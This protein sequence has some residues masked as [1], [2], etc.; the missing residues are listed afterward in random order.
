LE[1]LLAAVP[2]VCRQVGAIVAYPLCLDLLFE[3]F[4]NY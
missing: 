3:Q 2:G 1:R 4:E